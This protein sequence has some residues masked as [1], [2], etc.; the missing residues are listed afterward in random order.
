[1]PRRGLNPEGELTLSQMLADPIVLALMA[2]DGVS[3]VEVKAL[4]NLIRATLATQRS[5]VRPA[6]RGEPVTV[7]TA[8]EPQSQLGEIGGL[9]GNGSAGLRRSLVRPV[10]V[11]EPLGARG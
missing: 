11:D 3:P 1:M 6:S 7:N 9:I 4:V 8:I 2:S 5:K 10:V